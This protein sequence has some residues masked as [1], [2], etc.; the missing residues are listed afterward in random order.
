AVLIVQHF[1]EKSLFFISSCL[2]IS[3][4]LSIYDIFRIINEILPPPRDK[5]HYNYSIFRIFF[6]NF[7]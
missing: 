3:K 6:L 2:H 4:P 1:D 5:K 7:S